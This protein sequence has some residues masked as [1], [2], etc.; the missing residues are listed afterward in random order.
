M[1]A[2]LQ[3]PSWIKKMNSAGNI[4]CGSE[5]GHHILKGSVE[6][7]KSYRDLKNPRWSPAS[8]CHLGFLKI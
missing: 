1:A 2:I 7:F 8:G 6:W 3:Q 4:A 5:V